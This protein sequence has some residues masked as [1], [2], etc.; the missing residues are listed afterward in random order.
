LCRFPLSQATSLFEPT[1]SR[2]VGKWTK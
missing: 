1:K 2:E